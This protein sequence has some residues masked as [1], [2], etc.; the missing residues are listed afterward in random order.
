MSI[1][2]TFCQLSFALAAL[3]LSGRADAGGVE[4][5]LQSRNTSALELAGN[6]VSLKI[7]IHSRATGRELVGDIALTLEG[8]ETLPATDPLTCAPSLTFGCG[9]VVKFTSARSKPGPPTVLEAR[10]EEGVWKITDS[11]AF[12]TFIQGLV[13]NN[14]AAVK[15]RVDQQRDFVFDVRRMPWPLADFDRDHPFAKRFAGDPVL[16]ALKARFPARYLKIVTLARKEAPPTGTLSADAERRILDALHATV[17]GLRPM[18]SD[19]LL[20][21]IVFN[22]SAAAKTV[23]TGDKSLCNALAV[24]SRSAVT[25]P[26][27]EGTEL[28][29]EEYALWQQVV[30][31]AGPRYLRKVPN[32][33]LLPSTPRFEENVRV[34]N[35]SGCGMFAA[36]I[37]AILALP[38]DERRLWLRAT[39]GTT[40]DLRA[41]PATAPRQ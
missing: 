22:A 16:A 8:D 14:T 15:V 13:D 28:A 6:P 5:I 36:V 19:E 10:L 21:R 37:E 35:E 17:G 29:R 34:A 9:V 3:A 40:E 11:R 41:A 23:G 20:E 27:L 1:A 2:A 25:T 30:E 18:V 24:A 31:Q 26:E 33:D 39:V 12:E 4:T 7:T 32:E 38:R